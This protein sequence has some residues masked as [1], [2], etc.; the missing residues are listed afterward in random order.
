VETLGL[1]L[2]STRDRAIADAKAYCNVSPEAVAK[3]E[4]RLGRAARHG[5]QVLTWTQL[6]RGLALILPTTRELVVV[7]AAVVPSSRGLEAVDQIA[8]YLGWI[9]FQHA[10]VLA[11]ALVVDERHQPTPGFLRLAHLT[12]KF[13]GRHRD[14]H[15]FFQA[16]EARRVY[17]WFKQL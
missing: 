3:I 12:G 16:A 5:N 8:M 13:A 2:T 7:D 9:S 4:D 14:E 17:A 6:A 15:I 11:N 10:R 1:N